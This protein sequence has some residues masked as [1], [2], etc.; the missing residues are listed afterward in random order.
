MMG[1]GAGAG[2]A[3]FAAL[4]MWQRF[5]QSQVTASK[6]YDRQKNM[7]TR[8]PTYMMQG[9]RNAGINPIL[10]AGKGIAGGSARAPQATST[11][12]GSFDSKAFLQGATKKLLASQTRASDSLALKND[13]DAM[14]S[15][16]RAA[17]EA[18]DMPRQ[19]W[20]QQF[21]ASPEGQNINRILQINSTIPNTSAGVAAKGAANIFEGVKDLP[22]VKEMFRNAPAVSPK[23]RGYR[24][25]FDQVRT[26]ASEAF[27]HRR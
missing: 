19:A 14:L 20:L 5:G 1:G 16:I 4:D 18:T 9:L 7:M 10:A 15:N 3:G 12:P 21:W 26:R 27:Q 22:M 8:G 2:A 13:A 6:S 23:Y 25:K 17:L 24:N 11:G